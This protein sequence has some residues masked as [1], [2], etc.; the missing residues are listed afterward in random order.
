MYVSELLWDVV[1]VAGKPNTIKLSSLQPSCDGRGTTH[2]VTNIE[3]C[4]ADKIGSRHSDAAGIM[5]LSDPT[6]ICYPT[7]HHLRLPHASF[8]PLSHPSTTTLQSK[9]HSH[10]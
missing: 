9:Y 3:T 10:I 8:L 4:T 6:H 7:S 2:H 1:K 5:A